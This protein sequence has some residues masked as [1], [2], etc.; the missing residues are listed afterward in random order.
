MNI[1][2]QYTYIIH[3]YTHTYLPS[4][5]KDA[6]HTCMQGYASEVRCLAAPF[7]LCLLTLPS[8]LGVARDETKDHT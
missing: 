5:P 1:R 6:R 2:V 7:R 3:T 4:S 8:L